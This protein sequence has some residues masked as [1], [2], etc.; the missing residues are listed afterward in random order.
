MT[1][2]AIIQTTNLT[3][4][5]KN[6][7]AVRGVS[8]TVPRGGVYGFLGPNGAGKSTTIRMLLGLLTPDN[9]SVAVFG[10]SLTA[11][12][13]AILARTGSLVESPSVYPHL[14]AAENLDITRRILGAPR[15]DITRTLG[16]V[17][18]AYAGPKLVRHFSLGMKQR[19]GLA[20]ALVGRRELLILDEPTNGL[21]PAGINDMRQLIRQLP[22]EHGIT[23]LLSSHL[24]SE[25][26]QVATLVGILSQGA[27]VFQG[28]AAEVDTLRQPRLRVRTHRN[29]AALAHVQAHGWP[30]QLV[31]GDLV[32]THAVSAAVINR[33]LIDAGFDVHHVAVESATL[34][35]IFL[36]MT[37]A[38][39]A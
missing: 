19:L 10:Q 11:H 32:F 9:G 12:R 16:I 7:A 39:V 27:L 24:L 30:A 28:T 5:F 23:V 18:L 8:L 29:E 21:D 3:K 15:S 2:D 20:Q 13:G 1:A 36:S 26:E 34:E 14:T 37:H 25:V 33:S 4:R 6:K 22:S 38:E 31:D 35:D 17:G